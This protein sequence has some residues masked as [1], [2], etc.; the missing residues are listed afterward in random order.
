M[1]AQLEKYGKLNSRQALKLGIEMLAALKEMHDRNMVHQD[2]KPA[3]ILFG[4]EPE[5]SQAYLID[6]GISQVSS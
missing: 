4:R 1:K 6:F 2:I 3:N 5:D